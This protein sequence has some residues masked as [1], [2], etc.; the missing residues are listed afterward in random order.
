[1]AFIPIQN[2]AHF[3]ETYIRLT[4]SLAHVYEHSPPNAKKCSL[5]FDIKT[6]S[7]YVIPFLEI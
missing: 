5:V 7:G 1:M 3:G 4:L 6:A 2:L